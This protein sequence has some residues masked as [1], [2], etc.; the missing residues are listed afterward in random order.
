[1][2][3]N[4]IHFRIGAIDL[5]LR[6]ELDEVVQEFAALYRPFRKDGNDSDNSIE[7]EVRSDRRAWYGRRR[8]HVFGDDRTIGRSRRRPEVM[9]YLEW[10]INRQVIA[11]HGEFLQVHAASLA[12]GNAGVIFAANSGSGKSTLAA[13]LLSRGWK[14]LSDEFALIDA[15]TQWLHPFPKALC[16]KSGA[17]KVVE[18]LNLHP[19]QRRY[20]VKAFKGRVG[21]LRPHDVSDQPLASPSPIRFV[22]FPKYIEGAHPRL[23]PLSRAQAAFSLAKYVMNSGTFGNRSASLLADVVRQAVCFG[24]ESGP[25][26]AT[27]DLI[28]SVLPE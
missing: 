23:F 11:R 27:C 20:Y 22:I 10:G 12:R 3:R 19:W 28:E 16:I 15:E 18:Q 8:Y 21:Y 9:P 4:P 25:L 7:M 5:S 14:Y 2:H 24:L 26:E 1:M 6:S 13:G 17:F